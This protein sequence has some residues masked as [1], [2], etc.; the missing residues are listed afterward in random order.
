MQNVVGCLRTGGRQNF[1]LETMLTNFS[2]R[3][4]GEEGK[5]KAETLGEKREEWG[6]EGV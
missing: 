2:K 4:E 6:G 3:N 5:G 1:C